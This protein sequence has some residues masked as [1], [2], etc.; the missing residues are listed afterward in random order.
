[1]EV[2]QAATQDLEWLSDR[3]DSA[4]FQLA[5]FEVDKEEEAPPERRLSNTSA[6]LLDIAQELL[7]V[8][9]ILH[10]RLVR[11]RNVVNISPETSGGT[12][13]RTMQ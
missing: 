8:A 1:M 10:E 2:R 6:F 3:I 11:I 7:E 12:R 13:D 5:A 9:D 4:S